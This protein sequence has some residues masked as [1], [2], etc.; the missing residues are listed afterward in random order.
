[1]GD[2]REASWSHVVI[3]KPR[4]LFDTGP[5]LDRGDDESYPKCIP[6]IIPGVDM[7]DTSSWR[8]LDI[9]EEDD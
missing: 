2:Q 7:S 4:D 9:Q 1:M 5:N 8:R 6:F 3:I